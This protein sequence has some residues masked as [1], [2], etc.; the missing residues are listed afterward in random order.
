MARSRR[1]PMPRTTSA[2]PV[3]PKRLERLQDP[4]FTDGPSPLRRA[5]FFLVVAAVIATIAAAVWGGSSLLMDL[6]SR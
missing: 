3:H 2:R 6:I 1:H 4:G 5:G